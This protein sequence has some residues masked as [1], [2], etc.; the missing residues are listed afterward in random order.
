MFVIQNRINIVQNEHEALYS[1]QLKK[2]TDFRLGLKK[3]FCL[4]AG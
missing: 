3:I 4:E 2:K 1:L